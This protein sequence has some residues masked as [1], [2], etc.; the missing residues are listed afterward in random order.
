MISRLFRLGL[1]L[2]LLSICCPQKTWAD[3]SEQPPAEPPQ[4]R[5]DYP[6]HPIPAP[7][8][9]P[10]PEENTSQARSRNE[11]LEPPDD[12]C[13]PP[14]YKDWEEFSR[15]TGAGAA[16]SDGRL[17]IVIDRAMFSLV[18]EETSSEGAPKVV[19]HTRVALGDLRSPTPEGS[20]VIN[21]IYCYPDVAY[22]SPAQE[23]VSNLYNGFFAP[24]L[25]CDA[26]GKCPRF[27]SLGLHGFLPEARPDSSIRPETFGAVS[28]GCIRLPDPCSFKKSL[29]S[30]ARLGPRRTND[31]GSYHWL[32][33]P[34]DVLI[35]NGYPSS[36]DSPAFFDIFTD[37][38]D[39]LGKGLGELFRQFGR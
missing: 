30:R 24:L 16:T 33:M 8:P 12:P 11:A 22:F 6:A 29:I 19:Y 35:V 1:I 32:K 3:L 34:I 21:H 37:S 39:R 31:R 28:G 14:L 36:A 10:S 27:Q 7:E 25:L 17:R 9:I 23:K 26:D 13:L 38:L 2:C 18:L 4:G 20:F 5:G 15:F